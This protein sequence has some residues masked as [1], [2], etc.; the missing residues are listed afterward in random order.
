MRKI[1]L[2]LGII[3]VIAMLAAGNTSYGDSSRQ[4][5]I[6]APVVEPGEK[7][8]VN[9]E[10]GYS[11]VCQVNEDIKTVTITD[12]AANM[13]D[14]FVIPSTVTAYGITF[15]VTGIE[16]FAF[17]TYESNEKKSLSGVRQLVISEGI[18]TIGQN[19]FGNAP[20]LETVYLP[21]SLVEIPYMMFADSPKLKRVIIPGSSNMAAIGSFAFAGCRSLSSFE[22]PQKVAVIKEGPWRGCPALERVSISKSNHNFVVDDGVLYNGSKTDLIQYPAGKKDKSYKVAAGTKAICNSAFY[23]SPYL[24]KVE[25]PA[26]IDSISH[27]AFFDCASLKEVIFKEPI[28]FIGNKAFQECP[29]LREITLYGSPKYT[30]EPGDSYNT[31]Q[32]STKVTIKR[33]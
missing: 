23:G 20:D 5:D 12:G 14:S 8:R 29:K 9:G 21:A 17:I 13:V 31:F 10:N 28:Q 32:E 1:V 30:N 7:F 15:R 2:S 19:C 25:L 11:L 33:K 24:E 16:S 26:S 3:A 18:Q 4:Q 27:I 22:I 6:N